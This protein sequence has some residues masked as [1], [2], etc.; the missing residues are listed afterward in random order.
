MR[1]IDRVSIV[2][3]SEG[4]YNP[5]TGQFDESVQ[6]ITKLPCNISQLGVERT[7]Q[8]FG[9]MDKTILVVRL[10]R[11]YT[12]PYD[13]LLIDGK[14]YNVK[15]HVPHRRESVFYAEGATL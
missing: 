14:R 6:I 8:L 2:T 10:Q 9:E 7:V 12:Q 3:E 4:G 11:P 15:R 5:S 13:Y 1:F